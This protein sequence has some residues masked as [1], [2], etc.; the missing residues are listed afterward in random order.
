M[1]KKSHLS[2]AGYL[3]RSEGFEGLGEHRKAF[4][5]GSILPDCV[6]SFIT[7]KHRIDTT[8]EI[9]KKEIRKL[10]EDFNP[11]KGLNRYYCRHL[12]VITH[13]L[14]DYFTYP[15]NKIFQGNLRE[16]CS[17]EK[18][19]TEA[20]KEYVQSPEAEKVR[21]KNGIFRTVDEICDFICRMHEEYL[22]AMKN[23]REDCRYI[24]ELCH[25]V[26]DAILQVLEWKIAE[27]G[28]AVQLE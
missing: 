13:Y 24:V 15:H 14:A 10:T 5:L 3:I 1:K 8:F 4:Y 11:N 16:H 19:L 17:Y 27:R 25:R 28:L 6:P 18:Q 22:R 26:V 9:L 12:G 7:R 21:E 2:L 23:I 20:V